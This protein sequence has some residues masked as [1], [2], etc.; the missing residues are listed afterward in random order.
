MFEE[1]V[2]QPV[3]DRLQKL[4]EELERKQSEDLTFA[5]GSPS[6]EPIRQLAVNLAWTENANGVRA[7]R[8][9]KWLWVE[10]REVIWLASVA[11][12][13]SVLS[14]GV[15]VALAFVHLD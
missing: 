12:G 8:T 3:P 4:L 11:G 13:L 10:L 6:A 5:A 2:T 7:M 15:A 14:V 9:G 1:V